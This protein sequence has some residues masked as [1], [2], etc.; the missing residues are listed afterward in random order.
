MEPHMAP[1]DIFFWNNDMWDAVSNGDAFVAF[2]GSWNSYPDVGYRLDHVVFE[3]GVPIYNI[4]FLGY[5]GPGA[6][7]PGWL[8]PVGIQQISHD[9]IPS[10]LLSSDGTG[11]IIMISQSE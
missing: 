3:E 6:Y 10:L 7:A 4:P 5:A 2:H 8:R 1:L 9:G 11:Q